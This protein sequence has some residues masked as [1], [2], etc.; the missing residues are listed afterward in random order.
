MATFIPILAYYGLNNKTIEL[1]IEDKA[2]LYKFSLSKIH[3]IK[4][5][6]FTTKVFEEL[7]GTDKIHVK[8]GGINILM[9]IDA[10]LD[11]LYFIPFKASRLNITNLDIDV[12][13]ESTSND[14]VHW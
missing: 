4:V 10:E 5:S 9:D 2:R 1:D 13:I 11:A 3:L 6:G 8:I 12:T 7:P 14:Q